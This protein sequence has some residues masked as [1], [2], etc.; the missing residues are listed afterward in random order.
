MC[1]DLNA[2]HEQWLNNYRNANG[3]LLADDLQL[4]HYIVHYPDEPTFLAP[5]G[6]TSTLDLVLSNVAISKPEVFTELSSDHYPVL[7]EISGSAAQAPVHQRKNFHRVNWDNFNRLVDS[8]INGE[9]DL[10]TAEDI[11]SALSNLYQAI[12]AADQR[13][14]KRVPV[15]GKCTDIDLGTKS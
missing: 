11:D 14:V 12:D 8:L 2:R 13:F 7:C 4:G 1:G 6:T 3:I 10:R 15:R 9:P 5:T